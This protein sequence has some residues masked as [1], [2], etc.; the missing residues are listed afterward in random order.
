MKYEIKCPY[1]AHY[2]D[3]EKGIPNELA[4][5]LKYEIQCPNCN[6]LFNYKG[7]IPDQMA[8]E[9]KTAFDKKIAELKANGT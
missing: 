3:W 7:V 5:C 4:S 2:F 1:C 9:I 6:S 8:K